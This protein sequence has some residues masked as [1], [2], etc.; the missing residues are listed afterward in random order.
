MKDNWKYDFKQIDELEKFKKD[1][2]N[3]IL[4]Q[5]LSKLYVLKTS[6]GFSALV[7]KDIKETVLK[8]KW[9]TITNLGGVYAVA[10]IDKKRQYLQNYI[11]E[12]T[13][14][15]KTKHITFN[16]K[17]SLDCR[18]ENLLG[19]SR[20]AVMHNRRGKSG[21]TSEFKN[22]WFR[23]SDGKWRV[24]VQVKGIRYYFGVHEDEVEAAEIADAGARLLVGKLAFLNLPIL[25]VA[26]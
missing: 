2:Q 13:T 14:G 20:R 11:W 1:V 12:V 8:H 25:E 10:D 26:G 3:F 7:D 23:P 16:N 19:T 15:R 21:T 18:F 9:Y 6:R 22:V 4:K 5:D 17:L 24:S